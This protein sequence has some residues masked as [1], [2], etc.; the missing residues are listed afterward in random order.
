MRLNRGLHRAAIRLTPHHAQFGADGDFGIDRGQAQRLLFVVRIAGEH[1][2]PHGLAA[3]IDHAIVIRRGIV[4]QRHVEE[5]VLIAIGIEQAGHDPGHVLG[6]PRQ[7]DL[8]ALGCGIELFERFAAVEIVVELDEAA[9]TQFPR[10]EVVILDVVGHERAADRAGRF[11]A[12]RAQPFAKL[13]ELL[14]SVDRGQRRG[15]PPRFQGVRRISAAAALDQPE[16]LARLHDRRADV[17]LFFVRPPEFEPRRARHAVAQRLHRTAGDGHR[18]HVEELELFERAAMQLFD[19]APSVRALDLEAPFLARDGLAHRPHRR[20]VIEFDRH[21]VA[22]GFAVIPQPV[23]RRRATDIGKRLFFLPEHDPVTDHVAVRR[24]RHILLG[25]ARRPALRRVDHRVRQQLARITPTDVE[26]DHVVRL[27]EQHRAVLPRPLFGPP[28]RKLGRHH[29]VNIST[30]LR[31]AQHFDRIAASLQ[32]V[33]KAVGRHLSLSRCV[34]E[35][36]SRNG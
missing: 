18:A 24:G 33:F 8:A 22:A 21:V 28:V 3:G 15:N 25:L 4:R 5:L 2:Q 17:F 23:R 29:R 26:I 1:R 12:I 20:T 35:P 19:H 9:V 27:V 16:F 32:H 34:A 11:V 14:A 31:I 36:P 13:L 6:V 30:K 7:R 10:I